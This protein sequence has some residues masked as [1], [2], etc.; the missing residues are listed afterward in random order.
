VIG[1]NTFGGTDRCSSAAPLSV[2]GNMF[3]V[4]LFERLRERRARAI[5]HRPLEH[6]AKLPNGASST[7]LELKPQSADTFFRIAAGDRRDLAAS[8]P[9]DEFERAQN[10]RQ[11]H[12]AA[13]KTNA[14]GCRDREWS[15]DPS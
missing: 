12:R 1:W 11:R 3:Q 9:A 15:R 5:R 2:A 13:L 6:F 4:R 10:R 7:R 14:Y 8:R